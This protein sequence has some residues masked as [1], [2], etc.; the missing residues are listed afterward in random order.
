MWVFGYGS[1]IWNPGFEHSRRV[2]ARLDGWKLRFWQASLDHRG[3]PEYP[4]RVATII[5]CPQSF[6]WGHAYYLDK[7]RDAILAYLDHREKGGYERHNFR[8]ETEEGELLE[9]LSYV[10]GQELSTYIGPE[11]E[12]ETARIIRRAVGPSGANPDYLR[13]LYE[14]LLH[15]PYVEPHV[16]R[17]LQLVDRNIHSP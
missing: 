14:S 7:D 11:D 1:L 9:A 17:L 13:K 8:L 5:P 3:T 12:E 4:G 16:V 2:R 15:F 6:V 10:G